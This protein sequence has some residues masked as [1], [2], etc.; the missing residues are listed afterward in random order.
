MRLDKLLSNMGKGSRNEMRDALKFG[1][2]KVNGCVVKSGKLKVDVV[3]DEVLFQGQKV[4][5]QKHIYLMMNKPQGV[6]SAT[7]DHH[8]K[9]VIDLLQE[10]VNFYNVFPVG[11]LDMDT[12]G[13]LLLTDDGELAHNLLSPK[14]HVP[15]LY[16][17]KIDAKVT[18]LDVQKFKE[19]ITIDDGYQCK[20]AELHI[21]SSNESES[22]IEL[23]IYEGKFHQVKRMFEAVEKKVTFLKRMKMGTLKLDENLPK[24]AYRELTQEELEGLVSGKGE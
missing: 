19:G 9:T 10:D 18:D 7:E 24:G 8:H 11:R 3:T 13:L 14:K 1:Q 15:K 21:L 20:P 4:T 16:F 23:V 17:A 5:Y 2:V 6:I 22:E 12:E